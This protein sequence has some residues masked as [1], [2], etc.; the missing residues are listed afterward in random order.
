MLALAAALQALAAAGAAPKLQTTLHAGSDPSVQH[1]PV[2]VTLYAEALCPY[3]CVCLPEK[4]KWSLF[5]ADRTQAPL[6]SCHAALASSLT[7][8]RR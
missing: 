5:A 3:W 6:P 8:L 7:P 1:L 2:N 4:W